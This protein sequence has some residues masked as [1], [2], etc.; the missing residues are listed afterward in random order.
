MS[1]HIPR[2]YF[3]QEDTKVAEG[4]F[5]KINQAQMHH[6]ANVLRLRVGDTVK[7]FGSRLD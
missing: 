3:K 7:I 4:E 1:R 2:F 5:V 6:A